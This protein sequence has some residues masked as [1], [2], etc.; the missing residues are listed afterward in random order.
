MK[1]QLITTALISL[2]SIS[3]FAANT[4][5]LLTNIDLNVYRSDGAI[6]TIGFVQGDAKCSV[7]IFDKAGRTMINAGAT[8]ELI[9]DLKE[10]TTCGT[11][12]WR[13]RYCIT[14]LEG[15]STDEYSLKINCKEKGLFSREFSL[16]RMSKDL[17]EIFSFN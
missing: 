7:T 15:K 2:L 17:K 9:G 11:D 12:A 8:F 5:T 13:R 3:A 6:D 10:A 16:K 1:K 4:A 14:I